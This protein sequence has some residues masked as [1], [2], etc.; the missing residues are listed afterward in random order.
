[1]PC[2]TLVRLDKAVDVIAAESQ[3]RDISYEIQCSSKALNDLAKLKQHQP[4]RSK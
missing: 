4:G 3:C 2:Y 1:M